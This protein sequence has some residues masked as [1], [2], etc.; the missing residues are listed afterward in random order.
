MR[1]TLVIAVGAAAALVMAADSRRRRPTAVGV[2]EATATFSTEHV[3]RLKAR[4]LHRWGRQAV[5]RSRRAATRAQG[6]GERPDLAGP[7]TI[8]G[9]P[10]GHVSAKRTP[11][12]T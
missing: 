8:S 4:E 1:K 12:A 5:Q 10:G 11:S 2:S 6:L 9:A 3:E 7:I